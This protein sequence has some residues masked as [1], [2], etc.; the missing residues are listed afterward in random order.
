[1]TFSDAK[2]L[3]SGDEIIITSSRRP[4][5]CL[6]VIGILIEGK[7]VF[8]YCEDGNSYHHSEAQFDED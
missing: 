4:Y 8:I 5:P 7:N 6:K 1:M 2:K 3:H